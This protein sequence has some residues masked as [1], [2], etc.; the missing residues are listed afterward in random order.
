MSDDAPERTCPKCGGDN[1][2]YAGGTV[3]H[4]KGRRIVETLYRCRDCGPRLHGDC[5]VRGSVVLPDGLTP[6]QPPPITEVGQ[7]PILD[8]VPLVCCRTA[9]GVGTGWNTSYGDDHEQNRRA[10]DHDRH[11]ASPPHGSAVWPMMAS[12]CSAFF[13][14]SRMH[15]RAT[16]S[17]PCIE[18]CGSDF[19]SS[20]IRDSRIVDAS[21]SETSLAQESAEASPGL[22]VEGCGRDPSSI[23]RKRHHSGGPKRAYRKATPQCWHVPRLW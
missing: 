2:E 7:Y 21:F 4:F 18:L 13:M 16:T 1:L 8:H 19:S 5:R 17:R 9:S 3:T 12:S 22:R 15:S 23:R 11:A 10:D 20:M 6:R 14:A